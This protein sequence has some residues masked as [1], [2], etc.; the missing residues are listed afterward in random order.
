M[1][2]W[3]KRERRIVT[4]LEGVT[5]PGHCDDANEVPGNGQQYHV[6]AHENPQVTAASGYRPESEKLD[7]GQ[8]Q[9]PQ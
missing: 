9:E 6:D 2:D 7:A 5:R 3:N 1:G 8:G 4:V